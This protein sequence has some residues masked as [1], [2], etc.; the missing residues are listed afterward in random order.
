MC[1]PFAGWPGGTA[2]LI[3]WLWHEAQRPF[4]EIAQMTATQIAAIVCYPRDSDGRLDPA[5]QSDRT[6]YHEECRRFLWRLGLTDKATVDRYVA[7]ELR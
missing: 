7:G 5:E 6:P 1:R 4:A 3:A 2:G